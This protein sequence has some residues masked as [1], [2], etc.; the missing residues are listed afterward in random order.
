[1]SDFGARYYCNS[2]TSLIVS[3]SD[4]ESGLLFVTLLDMTMF[5]EE[6]YVINEKI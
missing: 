6:L 4:T 1:L 5:K 2:S 3:V